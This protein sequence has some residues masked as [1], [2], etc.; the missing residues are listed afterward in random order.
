MNKEKIIIFTPA[1]FILIPTSNLTIISG[2][3]ALFTHKKNGFHNGNR[4]KLL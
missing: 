3:Y 4:S 1:K 2:Y